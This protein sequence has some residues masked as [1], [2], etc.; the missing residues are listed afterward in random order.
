MGTV[1]SFRPV[2]RPS[3]RNLM[4]CRGFAVVLLHAWA[5]AGGRASTPVIRL[6]NGVEM[7]M[8]AVGTWQ[9][10]DSQA[11]ASISTSLREGF[12]MVD[13][14]WDYHNQAGVGKAIQSS[15]LP[16]SSIFV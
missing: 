2:D 11:E 14:A 6:R 15:G 7:P 5:F 10:N 4:S 3:R 16:R 12:N 8:L 9:Y 1:S 13:T